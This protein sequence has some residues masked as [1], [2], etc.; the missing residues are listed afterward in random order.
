MEVASEIKT[1]LVAHIDDDHRQLAKLID[2][3]GAVRPP[4]CGDCANCA[5]ERVKSCCG[6]LLGVA[7]DLQSF[8][9]Q[10]LQHEEEV[11]D[12]RHCP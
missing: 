12:Q 5:P 4:N 10:H 9:L 8:L 3:V 11:M 6:G 2:R 1:D 7:R